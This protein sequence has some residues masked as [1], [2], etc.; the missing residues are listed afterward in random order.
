MEIAMH[1]K[2]LLVLS[3]AATFAAP[4]LGQSSGRGLEA[5]DVNPAAPSNT[6]SAGATA[7]GFAA[8]DRNNDGYISREEGRD[9]SWNGRFSELDKDNDGRLSQ[10]EFDAMDATRGAAGATAG[11]QPAKKQ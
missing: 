9:A 6:P 4:V 3:L 8:M 2:K 7:G 10:S 5:K 1:L 11:D